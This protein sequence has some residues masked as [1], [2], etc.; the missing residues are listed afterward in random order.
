MSKIIAEAFILTHDW[1]F[2][3]GDKG[4]Y[5]I[6]ETDSQKAFEKFND[7]RLNIE[8][9]EYDFDAKYTPYSD[10]DMSYSVYE[11]EKSKVNRQ[12]LVLKPV[13]LKEV[14]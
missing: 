13:T 11:D 10:G 14:L 8:N 4:H 7:L 2:A 1:C 12:D 6:I 3:N 9:D 5:E